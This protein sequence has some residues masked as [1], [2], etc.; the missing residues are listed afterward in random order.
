MAAFTAAEIVK[1]LVPPGAAMAA[2]PKAA[3]TAKGA[4]ETEGQSGK[5]KIR[6]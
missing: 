2:G 3:V 1:T 5:R 4:P 6:R